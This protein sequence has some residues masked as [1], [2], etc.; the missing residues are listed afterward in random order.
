MDGMIRLKRISVTATLPDG[1]LASLHMDQ[2]A[3]TYEAISG[4]L[5]EEV[6]RT[7]RGE[8]PDAGEIAVEVTDCHV[9]RT[10]DGDDD[11]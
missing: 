9:P 5:H 7:F 6:V 4:F 3:A 1:R 2:T 10:P 8:F 11:E